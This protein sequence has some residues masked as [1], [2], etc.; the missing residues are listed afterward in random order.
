MTLVLLCL[1]SAWI[2]ALVFVYQGMPPKYIVT[3]MAEG[4]GV[5]GCDRN[6]GV[7]VSHF[8]VTCYQ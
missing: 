4:E 1:P 6:S 5:Q 8:D 3:G 2:E 7:D